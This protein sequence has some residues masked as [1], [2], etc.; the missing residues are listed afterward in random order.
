ME[1]PSNTIKELVIG[2][3]AGIA[4]ML[5]GIS[6]STMLVIMK[7]Y[8]R[9]IRD[10]S[11]LR[12]YLIKDFWYL[13]FI[14]LGA[15]IGFVLTAKL[16]DT[17]IDDHQFEIML[18]F[19]GLIG[20][21]IPTIYNMC[22]TKEKKDSSTAGIVSFVIGMAI[23]VAMIAL[24]AYNDGAE[25]QIGHDPVSFIVMVLVGVIVAVSILLPGLSHST[26]LVVIGLFGPFT[27]AVSD[28]DMG[29]L[30]PIVI[31]AIV[32]VL[33]FSKVIHYSLENHHH[34]TMMAILGL[35]VGS[36]VTI[37]Y[38]VSVKLGD[39]SDLPVGIVFVVIGLSLS[40]LLNKIGDRMT[41]S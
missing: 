16:L 18:L 2:I 34:I 25:M 7:A 32:G 36:L 30:L 21:Q 28:M 12:T 22:N 9:V 24:L 31:G 4:S 38:D 20:G 40:Y 29:L 10:M 17:V 37:L 5:P 11:R 8:E 19:V 26:I 13:F 23:M 6:G 39:L 3:I 41:V 33:L 1:K 15:G 27:K 14:I 35:T